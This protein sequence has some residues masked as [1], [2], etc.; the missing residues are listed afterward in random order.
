[1]S[2]KTVVVDCF[3]T[4]YKQTLQKYFFK[5]PLACNEN[6][7]SFYLHTTSFFTFYLIII[8]K[9]IVVITENFMQV[10]PFVT[11]SS[12]QRVWLGNECFKFD[13]C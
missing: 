10:R 1:M 9:K 12:G 3:H 8:I 2:T 4:I 7:E 5:L 13:A 6:Y 11:W